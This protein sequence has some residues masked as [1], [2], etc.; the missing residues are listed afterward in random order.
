MDQQCPHAKQ[1][2]V[3]TQIAIPYVYRFFLNV[4][5]NDIHNFEKLKAAVGLIPAKSAP[6]GSDCACCTIAF[7]N[8]CENLVWM[9]IAKL[10]VRLCMC[11]RTGDLFFFE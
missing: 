6:V 11:Q 2:V 3:E 5:T 8:Y 10:C 1:N 7:F 9:Q 4:Q